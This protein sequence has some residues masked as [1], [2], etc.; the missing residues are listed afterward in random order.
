M[1]PPERPQKPLDPNDIT[2]M[3][4]LSGVDLRAE[5]EYLAQS[6]LR[7]TSYN[8][9]FDTAHGSG[10]QSQGGNN[11]SFNTWS[12]G[13]YGSQPAFSAGPP[14]NRAEVTER[15]L[16]E[17]MRG[18][19][20]MAARRYAEMKAVHLR[21]PFLSANAVRDRIGKHAYAEHVRFNQTGYHEPNNSNASAALRPQDANARYRLGEDGTGI[22]KASVTHRLEQDSPVVEMLSLISLACNE[23]L[24]TLLEDA[25][26]VSR[27]RQYG[28]HGVVP[29]EWSSIAT[30]Q[31]PT[32]PETAM[33]P[34]L[35]ISQTP[36]DKV[37]VSPTP[38]QTSQELDKEK[39]K[40]KEKEKATDDQD[41]AS[42]GR[43]PTPPT[44]PSPPPQQT[45]RF[46]SPLPSILHS[47]A[48]SDLAAEKARIEKRKRRLASGTGTSASADPGSSATP[49]P[50]AA[51][52]EAS[53]VAGADAPTK[54]TKKQMAA[55]K[56]SAA[57]E[58]V[59]RKQANA[60][61]NMALGG[62]GKKYSW[63]SGGSKASS[64][65]LA[66]GAGMGR[67]VGTTPKSSAP[68]T[69][70]PGAVAQ[71]T[72]EEPGLKEGRWRKLGAWREDG[73]EGAGVQV[74]DLVAVLERDGLERKTLA[75]C[76]VRLKGD[77]AAMGVQK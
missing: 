18:K 25:Y 4:A 74:R 52:T 62:G 33:A 63:L 45:L 75:K 42:K 41:A 26:A 70:G 36:W 71:K 15:S 5:D 16:E 65:G 28:S 53:G 44:E 40:G 2:D 32:P 24:R 73:R 56:K 37:A 6:F 27:A 3:V 61:A 49:A 19:H 57:N 55:E 10:S 43:L 11:N 54:V 1:G 9:S 72:A 30:S 31:A 14:F 35:N 21:D 34:S 29:P 46:S 50:S 60:T 67:G 39:E 23:R 8:T 58:E 76:L 47:V 17:E 22:V 38:A 69:P 48:Q 77:E 68:S 13:N 59:Q 51:G 64:S 20:K 66:V 7:S 12:Q